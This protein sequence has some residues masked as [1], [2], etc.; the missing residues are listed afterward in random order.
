MEARFLSKQLHSLIFSSSS[1]QQEIYKCCKMFPQLTKLHFPLHLSVTPQ[2]NGSC[3]SASTLVQSPQFP[4]KNIYGQ[5]QSPL[6]TKGHSCPSDGETPSHSTFP[7]KDNLRVSPPNFLN[8]N[9]PGS[10]TLLVNK[11]HHSPNSV[12]KNCSKSDIQIKH[13][14]PNPKAPEQPKYKGTAADNLDIASSA[15]SCFMDANGS[16]QNFPL[17]GSDR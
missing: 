14:L 13:E 12:Q 11:V 8:G 4:A 9:Q 5:H 3:F 10:S 1:F 6:S 17:I 16:Q 15:T 2:L 7:S